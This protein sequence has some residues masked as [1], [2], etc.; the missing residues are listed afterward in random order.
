M[1]HEILSIKLWELDEQFSRLSSR[2]HLS[3]TAHH[4]QLQQQIQALRRECEEAEQALRSRLQHSRADLTPILAVAYD[5]AVHSIRRTDDALKQQ[6]L[7]S[8]S[9]EAGAEAK[10][11]LAEYALDFALQGA[12]R[13]LLLAMEAIDAQYTGQEG[14]KKQHERSE[15]T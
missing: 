7:A 2:I 3:E 9:P 5:E 4:P 14:E 13:A 10:I 15:R 6:V 1:A 11:L 12:N 8:G